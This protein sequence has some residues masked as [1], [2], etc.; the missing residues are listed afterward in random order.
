MNKKL[1]CV[2]GL[3]LV[4]IGFVSVLQV[5]NKFI[6]IV[7]VVKIIGISWFNCMEVGVKEF[8]VVNFGV[9]MCQIG[10]V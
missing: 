6:D 7:I 1:V 3:V 4:V 9:I 10:L 5:Q 8:V 2:L